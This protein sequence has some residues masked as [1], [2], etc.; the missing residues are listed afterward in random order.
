MT[1]NTQADFFLPADLVARA[2][3]SLVEQC[4][5]E[6]DRLLRQERQGAPDIKSER[7]FYLRQYRAFIKAAY[8][9][10]R[11]VRPVPTP[12]GGWLVPSGTRA[13]VVY[14]VARHGSVWVC[15]PSCEGRDGFHWHV[16]LAVGIERAIEMAD[17]EDDGDADACPVCDG[18]GCS[19]CDGTPLTGDEIA[20]QIGGPGTALAWRDHEAEQRLWARLALARAAAADIADLWAAS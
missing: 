10:G 13:G 9:W 15:G 8:H 2:L 20:D 18:A 16:A 1:D 6:I 11:G 3:A 4:H 12:T 17:E 14:E 19:E 5:D 7:V